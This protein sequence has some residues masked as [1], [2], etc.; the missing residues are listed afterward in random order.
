LAQAGLPGL[1]F[2]YAAKRLPAGKG[3]LRNGSPSG[4][5]LLLFAVKKKT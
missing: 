3:R 1:G 5:F 4:E 2:F